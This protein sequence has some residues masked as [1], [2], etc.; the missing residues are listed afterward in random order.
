MR[1]VTSRGQQRPL[2]DKTGNRSNS[3]YSRRPDSPGQR[4]NKVTVT[5]EQNVLIKM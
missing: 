1:L 5:F 4:L 2:E 3:Q